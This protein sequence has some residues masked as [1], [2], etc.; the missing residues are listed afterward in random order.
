MFDF[1]RHPE[2]FPALVS[3]FAAL[4]SVVATGLA[5]WATWK[6][7]SNAARLA[8]DLRTDSGAREQKRRMK[9]WIFSALMQERLLYNAPD[10]VKAFN[11]IDLVFIDS[12]QVRE[13]WAKFHE[14]LDPNKRATDLEARNRLR[15]LLSVMAGDLELSGK[16]GV[17][18]LERVYY[19]SSMA[20]D[21]QVQ[22]LQR[23]A[24]LRQLSGQA[25]PAANSTSTMSA[26]PPRPGETAAPQ[27]AITNQSAKY[28][29]RM[30]LRGIADIG[31][32]EECAHLMSPAL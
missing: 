17:A 16:L 31:C 5:A 29:S 1:A 4:L 18:D 7:P 20:E 22:M 27:I 25:G 21:L 15:E 19:P 13:A 12:F 24:L 14:A 23:Q 28:V 6:G 8:E 3:G 11:L 26:W 10:A 30:R 9:L 2:L 32:L